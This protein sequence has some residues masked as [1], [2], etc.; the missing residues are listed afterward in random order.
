MT[1]TAEIIREAFVQGRGKTYSNTNTDGESI[2]LFGN[3]IAKKVDGHT[4]VTFAGWPTRTTMDRIDALTS[5]T[6]DYF[7]R[8]GGDV[9][10]AYAD[11]H[12]RSSVKLDSETWIDT[13]KDSS[14]MIPSNRIKQPRSEL[15]KLKNS[16]I[17]GI[18]RRFSGVPGN[19]VNHS[20]VTNIKTHGKPDAVREL[21]NTS[22]DDY[23]L[24][25][26]ITINPLIIESVETPIIRTNRGRYCI[27]LDTKPDKHDFIK[28]LMAIETGDD[29]ELQTKTAYLFKGM[30]IEHSTRYSAKRW[31]IDSFT[32]KITRQ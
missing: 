12:S 30:V 13:N 15:S 26:D 3:K 25:T 7:Y 2:W 24:Q 21:K 17:D 27:V 18:H 23:S 1:Q 11:R 9:W 4:L 28:I 32:K 20:A 10:H 31:F 16:I 19:W 14:L 22:G 29:F 5:H 8:Q 6:N